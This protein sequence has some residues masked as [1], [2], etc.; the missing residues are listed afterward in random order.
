MCLE[1][2]LTGQLFESP[3]ILQDLVTDIWMKQT[4][5]ATCNA[6]IHLLINIPDFPLTRQGD[7]KL[8]QIFLQHRI[9][10][11]QLGALH[12][13]HMFLQVLHLSNICNGSGDKII[14][15]NW[16]NHHPSES[17]FNWPKTRK[18]SAVDWH[19]WNTT[20]T[21]TFHVDR[22]LNL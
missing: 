12:R 10:Q 19:T 20:I 9:C 18:P 13:C 22:Y 15:R 1:T 6:N 3:L 11:P 2:G 7:M 14:T 8:T 17:E 21:N 5:I 16:Q 4:W